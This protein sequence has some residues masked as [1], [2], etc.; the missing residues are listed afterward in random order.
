M[1]GNLDTLRATNL[2]Q[3]ST[4]HPSQAV[5]STILEENEIEEELEVSEDEYIPASRPEYG[6]P[7]DV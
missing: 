1:E 7:E 6:A 2:W 5:P 4:T 3:L